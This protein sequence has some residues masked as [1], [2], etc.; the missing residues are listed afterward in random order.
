MYTS[1]VKA[2]VK[3]GGRQWCTCDGTIAAKPTPK[4]KPAAPV[5]AVASGGTESDK[6][7]GSGGCSV[8]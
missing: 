7:K 4:P 5:S 8:Q 6:G 1:Q 3:A 2:Q